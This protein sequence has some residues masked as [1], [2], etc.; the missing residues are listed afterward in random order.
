MAKHAEPVLN[1]GAL[2]HLSIGSVAFVLALLFIEERNMC[3]SL[4]AVA[5]AAGAFHL[6]LNHRNSCCIASGRSGSTAV[7]RLGFASFVLILAQL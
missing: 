6:C 4:R 1:I 5:A 7:F 2:M 3:P